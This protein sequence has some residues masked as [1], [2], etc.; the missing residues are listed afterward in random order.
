ML[1]YFIRLI[2]QKTFSSG[3]GAVSR[4]CDCGAKVPSFEQRTLPPLF[5]KNLGTCA[6]CERIGK[7]ERRSL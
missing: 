4:A 7:K 1:K 3:N 5:D 2:F 6:S